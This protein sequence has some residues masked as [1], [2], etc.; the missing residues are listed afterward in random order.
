MTKHTSRKVMNFRHL[1][2]CDTIVWINGSKVTDGGGADCPHIENV[3]NSQVGSVNSEKQ[4]YLLP[5][6]IVPCNDYPPLD[7]IVETGLFPSK[8]ETL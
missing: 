3:L 4:A 2:G 8:I 7:N 1:L 5:K 6:F